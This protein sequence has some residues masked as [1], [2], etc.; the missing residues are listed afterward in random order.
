MKICFAGLENQ[1]VLSGEH[2]SVLQIDNKALFCRICQAL[3]SCKGAKAIEPY[4]VWEKD[5]EVAPAK[6]FIVVRDPFALPLGHRSL[7]GKLFSV[8][9]KE[10]L[11][12][13]DS[14][15][16]IQQASAEL[17]SLISRVGLQFN[18]DYSFEI[19]WDISRYLKTFGFGLHVLEDASLFDN[20][21]NFVDLAADMMVNEAIL[22]INLRTFLT[23]N[24]LE[25]L[26]ERIIFHGI[27]TLML[28]NQ[29]AEIYSEF[30]SKIVVDQHFIEY[31]SNYRP[32][33]SSSTQGRFCS[34]GFGAVAF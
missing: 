16:G 1:I 21:I 22:F 15:F 9:S 4:S 18:A 33:S 34:N 7:S 24:E 17:N 28:E 14:R 10:L 3:L 29:H 23:K 13:E 8:I 31:S 19:E 27:K 11:L 30:E 20:L 25:L 5:E 6:A 12:D 26:N 2:V 32:E